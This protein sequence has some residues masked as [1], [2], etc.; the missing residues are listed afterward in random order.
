MYRRAICFGIRKVR[1]V[2]FN[3]QWELEKKTAKQVLKLQSAWDPN[4]DEKPPKSPKSRLKPSKIEP[5]LG[6]DGSRT[7]KKPKSN[8]DPTKKGLACHSVPPSWRKMWPTWLQ[9]GFQNRAQINKK[10]IQ[11]SIKKLICLGIDFGR[12]LNDFGR[13]NGR[14]LR[15]K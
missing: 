15:S 14:N 4:H 13:E 10:S 3:Y 1:G 6:Q 12:V 9:V 8:I 11:K 2:L 5:K 7:S